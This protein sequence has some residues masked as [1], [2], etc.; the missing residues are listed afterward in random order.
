[1]FTSMVNDDELYQVAAIRSE[2]PTGV[3][4]CKARGS[5]VLSAQS[6]AETAPV[7]FRLAYEGGSAAL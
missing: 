6:Y 1:M 3:I 5:V 2:A 7:T 4:F